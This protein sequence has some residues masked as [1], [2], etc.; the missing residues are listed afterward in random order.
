MLQL[1]NRF[2]Q[3][4]ISANCQTTSRSFTGMP[5]HK[6]GTGGSIPNGW[7]SRYPPWERN[8]TQPWEKVWNKHL[9]FNS[10]L[11]KGDIWVSFFRRCRQPV[12]V[13]SRKKLA[14][15]KWGVLTVIL[16]T[17]PCHLN[18]PARRA[19]H[20]TYHTLP[21]PEDPDLP[22]KKAWHGN[23]SWGKTHYL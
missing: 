10:D 17:E 2:H 13:R 20:H 22:G 8:I 21:L 4:G 6:Y 7:P 23:V 11:S 9:R 1:V 12:V 19:W 14:C 18:D 5:W 3:P 16:T 15:N